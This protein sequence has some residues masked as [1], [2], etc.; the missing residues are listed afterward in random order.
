MHEPVKTEHPAL[1]K[2]LE[3]LTPPIL[4]HKVLDKFLRGEIGNPE[5]LA[6]FL[7][8]HPEA[9]PENV[10]EKA[11]AFNRFWMD[12]QTNM[13]KP[14]LGQRDKDDE[15]IDS[16]R[17]NAWRKNQR[18]RRHQM[19]MNDAKRI[20]GAAKRDAEHVHTR[21]NPPKA[22]VPEVAPPDDTDSEPDSPTPDEEPVPVPVEIIDNAHGRD[23]VVD[24]VEFR[25]PRLTFMGLWNDTPLG[26][27][28]L[29]FAS[30]FG[31]HL[32]QGEYVTFKAPKSLPYEI[33]LLWITANRDTTYAVYLAT[34][35]RARNLLR[36]VKG[37]IAEDI[38]KSILYVC[39]IAYLA[40]YYEQQNVNRVVKQ[41]YIKW[42]S[43]K[44]ALFATGSVLVWS[45]LAFLTHS[46]IP[47]L[48]SLIISTACSALVCAKSDVTVG[49]QTKWQRFRQLGPDLRA[50]PT[51]GEIV[52]DSNPRSKEFKFDEKVFGREVRVCGIVN[53]KYPPF[54][55]MNHPRN[56]RNGIIKRLMT[57]VVEPNPIFCQYFN[58]VIEQNCE[59]LLGKPVKI[60][61]LDFELWLAG[62]NSSVQV[63]S[64]LRAAKLECVSLG[65]DEDSRVA[66]FT[67]AY[68]AVVNIFGK[69]EKH[70]IE[71]EEIVADKAQR[72]IC[73]SKEQFTI[74]T[75]PFDT[76]VTGYLKRH[77]FGT[78]KVRVRHRIFWG[79]TLTNQEAATIITE[80]L[81]NRVL[82]KGDFGKFDGSQT[83]YILPT[84]HR[85][86]EHFRAPR[87]VRQLRRAADKFKG[88]SFWGFIVREII[89]IMS[90]GRT[91]T[92]KRNSWLNL[93]AN[94]FAISHSLELDFPYVLDNVIAIV[95]GDDIIMSLPA[96]W[97]R[98]DFTTVL[99]GLGL[100][101]DHHYCVDHS[102]VE[103]CSMLLVPCVG[104]YT[105]TPKVGNILMKIGFTLT[106]LP[107]KDLPAMM[108]GTVKS[109]YEQCYV[110]LPTRAF[111]DAHL[112]ILGE[113]PVIEPPREDWKMRQYV[114]AEPNASTDEYLWN[115]YGIG[116]V[117]VQEWC[118]LLNTV[119]KIG[120]LFSVLYD[121]IC[122]RDITGKKMY[123]DIEFTDE[124][125]VRLE[126]V[127]EPV[128]PTWFNADVVREEEKEDHN[129]EMH[130]TNGNTKP[131]TIQQARIE[132]Y[133]EFINSVQ[134]PITLPQYP[135]QEDIEE[136]VFV[137]CEEAP[138]FWI[139]Y[140]W[141]L[142]QKVRNALQHAANGNPKKLKEAVVAVVTANRKKK[143]KKK[144]GAARAAG[145]QM[146][147]RGAYTWA[148]GGA[149]IG[150]V[151]GAGLD[152]VWKSIT[153]RG[154]YKIKQN[155][156]MENT[157]QGP[158]PKFDASDGFVY[159]HS[160]RFAAVFGTTAFT[161]FIY[162]LNF[163][164]A[165]LMPFL[166]QL[167]MAFEEAEVMGFLVY[168]KSTSGS[169]TTSQGLGA[170]YFGANYDPR[171]QGFANS[172]AMMASEFSTETVPDK[173]CIFFIECARDR[174]VLVRLYSPFDANE[175]GTPTVI[176]TINSFTTSNPVNDRFT[177]HCNIV[178]ATQ[179]NPTTNQLGELFVSAKIRFAKPR[180]ANCQTLSISAT[181]S[182][183]NM[184]PT[185]GFASNTTSTSSASNTSLF[186]IDGSVTVR[187][188]STLPIFWTG[189]NNV[190]NHPAGYPGVWRVIID[191]KATTGIVWAG[192]SVSFAGG[193][194]ACTNMASAG[195]TSMQAGFQVPANG[196][197]SQYTTYIVMYY[198]SSVG[199][200]A[201]FTQSATCTG[202]SVALDVSGVTGYN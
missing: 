5:L 80:D 32:D 143:G 30:H 36:G 58:R 130:S 54:C 68:W 31:V 179:G 175:Y 186:V 197:T 26:Q 38:Y 147:G 154:S 108:R 127:I 188:G 24:W 156:L 60:G 198:A 25:F 164:N 133:R 34:E 126:A 172:T 202:L 145:G 81:P 13:N 67:A 74:H 190:F 47:M 169:V 121:V 96:S 17:R 115:R 9:K 195:N 27:G 110:C 199:G 97:A 1:K 93:T 70:L 152:S 119:T 55:F 132:A 180:L 53:P 167:A 98:V 137:K 41:A 159:S 63:K 101:A 44:V 162:P 42:W 57:Q 160:E 33:A 185:V 157:P 173:D 89:G 46:W 18:N 86:D 11:S 114:R 106:S 134:P 87:L 37:A 78:K 149:N 146:R 161:Q 16:K 7:T 14:K 135:T 52:Q 39:A 170:V 125:R 35:V 168:F 171:D 43:F 181:Q 59:L 151:L 189:G 117:F 166:V 48:P 69:D 90:S 103:F 131:V 201:T 73:A 116:P 12:I 178:I 4:N 77:I 200:T 84:V 120:P 124:P 193:L 23:V 182:Y 136:Y 111:L 129:R 56:E 142:S 82:V 76:A 107:D 177:T 196:D 123:H 158:V 40:S 3:K 85:T 99:G 191:I 21:S 105:F 79:S 75:G 141:S 138:A 174:N 139:S 163:T 140:V 148:E 28:P 64:M 45:A 118:A 22:D 91:N 104:G 83:E 50:E 194:T 92:T 94:L 150:G 183:A 20:A 165:Q 102:E 2:P 6:R 8:L 65:I 109:L 15:R 61:S 144:S 66:P 88:K 10:R 187:T 184:V 112:R 128:F 71:R 72:V 155:A 62:V 100:E 122:D 95:T 19:D 29:P 176:S 49:V 51:K 192:W 153:G 113:G